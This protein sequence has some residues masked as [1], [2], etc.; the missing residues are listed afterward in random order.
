MIVQLAD[1]DVSGDL[2]LASAISS[3]L[4]QYGWKAATGNLPASYLTGLLAGLRAKSKGIGKAVLDIGLHPPVQG[5]RVYA[6]LKGVIDAGLE[7]PHN[8]QILPSK[9]RLTG[10]HIVA[11]YEYFSDKPN[12][13]HMFSKL[14]K[15]KTT[16][17]TIPRQFQT[18]KNALLELPKADLKKRKRKKAPAKAKPKAAP[19]KKKKKPTTK[20]PRAVPKKP[21]PKKLISRGKSKKKGKR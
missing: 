15:K 11:A 3:E 5:S 16:V 10:K 4:G 17:T 9:D 2:I 18:V 8:P 1:A 20:A 21:K 19:A 6:A 13:S 14:G 7:I 12:G